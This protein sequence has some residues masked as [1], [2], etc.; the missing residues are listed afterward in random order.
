MGLHWGAPVLK[1]LIPSEAWDH[2]QDIQV[3]PNEP[4][5]VLDTMY[6]LNS[7]TGAR[8][9][10][11]QIDYFY[12]LKRSKL[13]TALSANIDIRYGKKLVD[14]LYAEDGKS[15]TAKFD[16][17]SET[18]GRILIGADGARSVA[19]QLAVGTDAHMSRRILFG[20]TFVQAKFTKE[21]A[22]H[23]RSWHEL[24]LAGVHPEGRFAF[25][26][27]QDASDASSPE[28]WI[29][30]F[31]ISYN[32]TLAEQEDMRTWPQAK[33]MAHIKEMAKS[34]ADPWKSAF[35]WLADDHPLWFMGLTDWDPAA[36]E[37]VWDNHGG[38]LTI[39]G[40]AAHTMTYQR[41]QGLNHSITD[42]AKLVDAI[43][44]MWVDESKR[45]EVIDGYETE[46]KAR[47]GT[48]VR[49]G[50]ANTEMLHNWEKALQSP[51]F[52]QGM[53]KG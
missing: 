48:E 3:D 4:T 35:A 26:G 20:A 15:V 42:A 53:N 28:S 23:L 40:D 27:I 51:L 14:V 43:K 46:M 1:T 25:F 30:F 33:L 44:M 52:K 13:R 19:R 49:M 7:A 2:I 9:G 10:A 21:Q 17:G 50:T 12:R 18:T 6:F 24:Y 31:Y 39:A 5:K 32:Q 37:H 29:F 38:R 34:H 36:P 8:I 45:A 41:G 11:A 47:A 16:D 22:L